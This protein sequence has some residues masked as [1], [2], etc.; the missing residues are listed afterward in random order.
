[1]SVSHADWTDALNKALDGRDP[2]DIRR[3]DMSVVDL[4]NKG[5]WWMEAEIT[6]KDGSQVT[7]I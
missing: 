5:G 1:M 6:Y 7:L 4:N 3:I 2:D